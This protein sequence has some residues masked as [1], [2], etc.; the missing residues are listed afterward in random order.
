MKNSLRLLMEVACLRKQTFLADANI[1]VML[2]QWRRE[3]TL[4]VISIS[5][6]R[7]RALKIQMV[8][9]LA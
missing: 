9:F 7:H 1:S 8:Y 6:E 2:V 5:P 4:P 3:G